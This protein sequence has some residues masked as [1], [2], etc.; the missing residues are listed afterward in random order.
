MHSKVQ[1][2][3][4]QDVPEISLGKINMALKLM[5]NNEAAV[6][7]GVITEAITVGTVP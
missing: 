4:S 2:Q 5:T 1:N 3:G 7:D 6:D